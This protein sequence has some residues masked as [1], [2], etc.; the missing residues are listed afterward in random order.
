MLS[1]LIGILINPSEE[2]KKIRDVQCTI[3]KCYCG[4]VFIMAAIIIDPRLSHVNVHLPASKQ[5]ADHWICFPLCGSAC[6][7]S[8]DR[9]SSLFENAMAGKSGERMSGG[10]G[11][12][13]GWR[14]VERIAVEDRI[15]CDANLSPAPP[16]FP[17]PSSKDFGE[18]CA[19]PPALLELGGYA[20]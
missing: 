6:D 14:S 17:R 15:P 7:C 16:R 11:Q 8:V 1:H 13:C 18:Q 12:P 4:Y 9:V 20:A 19:H 2:W 10:F 3:G 5:T